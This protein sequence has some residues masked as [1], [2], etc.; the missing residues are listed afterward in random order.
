MK[1]DEKLIK[2]RKRNFLSQEELAEKLD[3]TKQTISE[4]E[5]GQSKPDMDKIIEI[6]KLFNVSIDTLT[7]D[8]LLMEKTNEEKNNNIEYN[9]GNKKMILFFLIVIFITSTATLSYR[10]AI[11]IKEKNDELKEELRKEKEEQEKKKQELEDKIK[12]AEK[13]SF[14]EDY[15]FWAGTKTSAEVSIIIDK[16]I[17]NN[18]KNDEHLISFVFDG[19]SYGTNPENI[20]K[21]KKNLKDFNGY[22]IQKY[23]ISLNYDNEGYVNNIII[24][25][26]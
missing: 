14:N 18:K 5:L 4:W 17:T 10:I 26:R 21:I 20:I 11:S 8:N 22:K 2:L 19:K 3:V 7:N 6:S 16:A 24:E 13:E 12:K 1:F 9:N 25:T 15:E 23:E